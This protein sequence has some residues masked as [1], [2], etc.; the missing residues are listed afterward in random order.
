MSFDSETARLIDLHRI[1]SN[2]CCKT[3]ALVYQGRRS[4]LE[5]RLF[6]R[7]GSFREGGSV[8]ARRAQCGERWRD[9]VRP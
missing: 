5:R 1:I 2:V 4:V 9:N 7:N 8:L 6:T 3:I